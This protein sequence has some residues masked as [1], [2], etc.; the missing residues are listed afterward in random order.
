MVAQTDPQIFRLSQ[1][2]PRLIMMLLQSQEEQEVQPREDMDS[3]VPTITMPPPDLDIVDPLL[4]DQSP[5]TTVTIMEIDDDS[6]VDA[7]WA[8]GQLVGTDAPN[9]SE[10]VEY[11]GEDD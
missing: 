4:Q 11:K 7:N 2:K 1:N 8:V 9:N 10:L 3:Y 6:D 5:D